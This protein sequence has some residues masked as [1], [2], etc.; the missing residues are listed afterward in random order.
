MEVLKSNL[1]DKKMTNRNNLKLF[2]IILIC[3]TLFITQIGNAGILSPSLKKTIKDI[4]SDNSQPQKTTQS[5]ISMDT[6]YWAL[7]FAVG[8]YYNSPENDRPTMLEA[9]DDLYAT[10]LDSPNWQQDHI[11]VRKAADA[12]G[13]NL[14]KDLWWLKQNVDKDDYCLVYITT[15]GGQLTKNDLPLD[16]PPKDEE[17]GAD[18]VLVMYQGFDQWYSIIWDDLLNF[19]LGLIKAQGLCLIVDSCYSGGFNDDV[20]VQTTQPQYNYDAE[21]YAEDLSEEL[22]AQGRVV[23]M[24]CEEDTVSYG[25]FFS[26]FAIEGLNGEADHQG[27]GDDINS[28]E[29]TFNYAAPITTLFVFLLTGEEQ[30]PMM[31]DKFDGEFPLTY[32]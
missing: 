31:V 3:A 8:E 4:V 21:S 30:Y 20:F 6:E 14:I 29:E 12:T 16:L 1:G 17:D 13:Q 25:S 19:F 5:P 24:S 18:E 2:L 7:L 22:A 28:A 10:L 26:F 27:N 32:T 23:L 11:R 15:H 9:C